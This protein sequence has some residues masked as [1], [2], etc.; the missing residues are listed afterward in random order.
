MWMLI[1]NL[2]IGPTG[3][4]CSISLFRFLFSCYRCGVVWFGV[5]CVHSVESDMNLR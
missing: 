3:F 1:I 5:C 2:M 4:N